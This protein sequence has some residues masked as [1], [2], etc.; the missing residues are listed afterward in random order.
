MHMVH[1]LSN[2]VEGFVMS[3]EILGS[4]GLYPLAAKVFEDL[5]VEIICLWVLWLRIHMECT[6]VV[7]SLLISGASFLRRERDK[8]L[9][10]C[11]PSD[12]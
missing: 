6:L 11:K 10:P 5:A 4:T 9:D 7:S 3:F 2:F 8:Y 1:E 12:T